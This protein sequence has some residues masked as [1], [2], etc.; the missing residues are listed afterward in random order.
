MPIWISHLR[1]WFAGAA[2]AAVLTVAGIAFYARRGMQNALKQVPQ[3]IGVEIQQSATGFT[4][5]KSDQGRTVF[6]IDASRAVQFKQGG[7]V[8]LHDVV[9]TVYGRDSERYDRI[10]GS[11][12]EYNQQSGDVTANGEV[13]IDLEANPEGILNPDQS[14]P[15]QLKNSVHLR[16]SGLVFNQK[17]GDAYTDQK[18]EFQ[19]P[20]A[21]GSGEGVSY[22]A[23]TNV[24][25][26]RSHVKILSNRPGAPTVTA[27]RAVI[28]KD[29]YQVVLE[30]PE[31]EM[32][33]RSCQSDEAT[34]FLTPDNTVDRIVASRNVL[35]EVTAPQRARTRSDL[36]ELAMTPEN[37]LRSA[38]FSGAVKAEVFGDQSA[39]ADAGRVELKFARENELSKVRAENAV[40]I[41]QQ[42]K[43]TAQSSNA[44][45]LEFT[46]SAIDFI[47]T[48]GNRLSTAETSGVAQ[49]AFVPITVSPG[50]QTLV[51]AGKFEARFDESGQL[52]SL[53]G[54]PDARIVNKTPGQPDRVSTSETLDAG[55]RPRQGIESIVQQ[56]SVAYVDGD[57]KAW[58]DRAR[59]TVADQVLTLSGSPRVVEGGMTTTAHSMRMNRA[60]GDAFA[61][62]SVKTTYSDLKDHPNGALLASS[63]PIHVTAGTMSIH[64]SSAVALYSENAQLWQDTNKVQAPSIEFDRDQRAMLAL[65]T[66]DIPVSTILIQTDKNGTAIPVTL[67]SSRLSYMDSQ[68][69]AHLDENVTAKGSDMT[70]TAKQM[71]AYLQPRGEATGQPSSTGKLDKIVASG[72]VVITQPERHAVGNQ[73]VYT[74]ADDKFV[75][76]GGPPSIFDAEHGKI[77]GVSL[78]F[79]RRDARVLVEGD[80]KF[81]T[82]TQTRVAR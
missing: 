41:V 74:A 6:R 39:Y 17:T 14:P 71:D 50:P 11:D 15:K 51:T 64:G 52:S 68:R 43:A 48:N 49:I 78:T 7:R 45:N 44:Q 69:R 4:I 79:F 67:T 29:P 82:V 62:G 77:T 2:I 3:K 37:T 40:K 60:T 53:H 70:I 30:H 10:R 22:V 24:L 19:L 42:Q 12:F 38:I 9:I 21:N 32:I 1:R 25:T 35:M 18:V 65:G 26:L 54:A 34:I 72:Q 31:F 46:A 61:E 80:T 20:Q 33:A 81:P 28:T 27:Q 75:L 63:S 13:Q 47:L 5:S 76:T 23:N 59:Y 16:T 73:L 58:S 36:L 8:E 56:G 55:F 66:A 57:R